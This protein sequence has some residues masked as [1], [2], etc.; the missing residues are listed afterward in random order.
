METAIFY[1]EDDRFLV[2]RDLTSFHYEVVTRT[3]DPAAKAD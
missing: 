1:A 2:E 3:P